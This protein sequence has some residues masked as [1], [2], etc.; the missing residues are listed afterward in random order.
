MN[1]ITVRVLDAGTVFTAA[2]YLHLDHAGKIRP[3]GRGPAPAPGTGTASRP[4]T[5]RDDPERTG[6][7]SKGA[8]QQARA[9]GP[10]PGTVQVWPER[11]GASCT[12]GDT[13]T[14]HVR[15]HLQPE[16]P[17]KFWTLHQSCF[18]RHAYTSLTP[19]DKTGRKSRTAAQTP[20]KSKRPYGCLLVCV[21][22]LENQ[23]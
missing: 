21:A 14:G 18:Y 11:S 17:S 1:S 9:R 22:E 2:P 13:R 8:R 3:A 4:D 20:C 5:S 19:Y 6:R 7:I 23:G 16:T 15:P 10:T 12:C